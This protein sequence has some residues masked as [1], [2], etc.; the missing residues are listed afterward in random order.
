MI[1]LILTLLVV[2]EPGPAE[3]LQKP[4]FDYLLSPPIIHLKARPGATVKT[5]VSIENKGANKLP[6]NIVTANL[7]MNLQG[8]ATVA[9]DEDSTFSCR[10]WLRMPSRSF[11]LAPFGKMVVPISVT[12]PYSTSGGRYAIVLAHTQ[13]RSSGK[14]EIVLAAQMGCI[15]MLETIGRNKMAAG[16]LEMQIEQRREQTD[17]SVIVENSGDLH[18]KVKGS[19]IVSSEGGRI[20]DR[21]PLN[22]KTGTILPLHKRL[23]RASWKNTTKRKPGIYQAVVLMQ[24]PGVSRSLQMQKIFA[25]D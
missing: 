18:F 5:E 19:I 8:H 12:V 25:I 3:T 14:Q 22:I 24:V 7:G 9:R 11:E 23:F 10:S 13:K 2:L 21:I 20:I 15:I 1:P 17:F 16:I 6:V 4:V